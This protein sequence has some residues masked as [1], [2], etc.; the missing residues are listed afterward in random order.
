[1]AFTFFSPPLLS[2]SIPKKGNLQIAKL[3]KVF[4]VKHKTHYKTNCQGRSH[5]LLSLRGGSFEAISLLNP[6]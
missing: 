6:W 4:I 1:M 2:Y 3:P 5:P